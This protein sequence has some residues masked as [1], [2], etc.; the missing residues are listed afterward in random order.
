MNMINLTI[1]LYIAT[2]YREESK[3]DGGGGEG[4]REG[5]GSREEMRREKERGR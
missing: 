5:K 4:S 1:I 2:I 3:K